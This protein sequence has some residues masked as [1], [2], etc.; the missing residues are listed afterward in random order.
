MRKKRAICL[1]T[2]FLSFVPIVTQSWAER[3]SGDIRIF[4]PEEG[5][6][7]R[8]IRDVSQEDVSKLGCPWKQESISNR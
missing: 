8:E 1:L 4:L 3:M 6:V 5:Y 2:L 7:G